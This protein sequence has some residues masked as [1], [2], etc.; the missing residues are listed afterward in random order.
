MHS[1]SIAHLAAALAA[2][3]GEL[4]AVAMNS[5]NPFFKNRY[6]DL[7]AVIEAAKPVLARHGLSVAQLATSEP[8]QVGV[9][10]LLLHASGEWL[11][12]TIY[13]P[14]SE[15]RGKSSAQ[16]A[17][18]II[19]YLRRYALAAVLGMYADE[20]ADG[21]DSRQTEH[22][23]TGPRQPSAPER[24]AATAPISESHHSPAE[25]DAEF[26]GLK[27]AVDERAGEKAPDYHTA[28][29]PW[30]P[31]IV[32]QALREAAERVKPGERANGLFGAALGLLDEIGTDERRALLKL[33]FDVESSKDLSEAQKI[34][35]TRY[36][37]PVKA[38]QTPENP[39]PR[40]GSDNP[41]LLS[42]VS[43]M[44]FYG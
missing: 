9:T 12:S 10:T 3:Q 20:D 18:S 17:G 23:K 44:T 8:G 33:A 43:A 35:L 13:L 7:G 36:V 21:S 24:K 34:A 29:R 30:A 6:A 5:T 26:G 32:A 11:R 42:E 31:R 39:D 14:L 27:R 40:W 22:A 19:T 16:M 28:P 15:E 25:S 37:K 38:N 4:G 1:E 2:A 41:Y